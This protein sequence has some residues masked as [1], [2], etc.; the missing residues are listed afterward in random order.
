MK[1]WAVVFSCGSTSAVHA[2]V[3]T[4]YDASSFLDALTRFIMLRGIPQRV[5]SDRCTQLVLAEKLI[6]T[7]CQQHD[8]TWTFTAANSAWSNGQAERAVGLFKKYLGPILSAQP[9]DVLEF[10][11][12]L[13]VATNVINNRPIGQFSRSDTCPVP[14]TPAHF[15]TAAAIPQPPPGLQVDSMLGKRAA[16]IAAVHDKLVRRLSSEVL[17]LRGSTRKWREDVKKQIQVGDVVAFYEQSIGSASAYKLG[18]VKEVKEGEDG[19]IRS[20]K[21]T[22]KVGK[23]SH[24]TTRSVRTVVIL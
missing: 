3:T 17:E 18:T 12:T 13:A 4:S 10:T 23:V 11:T 6:R 8:V 24:V 15:L 5:Q 14:L 19:V 2:E 7:W 21:I 22:H 20:V 1:V 16:T 9:M